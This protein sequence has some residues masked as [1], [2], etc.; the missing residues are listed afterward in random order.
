[1]RTD[2]LI[3]DL[4]AR[5]WP[6]TRPAVRL[7]F[8]MIAAWVVSF[9][10]LVV[11]RGSPLAAVPETGVTPFAMKLGYSLALAMLAGTAAFAAGRPGQSPWR[12]AMLLALPF[13]VILASAMIELAQE[14]REAWMGMLFG[15]SFLGCIAAIS[16]AS[17]PVFGALVWAFRELAPTRPAVAGFLIGLSAGGAGAVAYA[18][19]CDETTASFLLASYTAGVL[20]PAVVGAL[21]GRRILRW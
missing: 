3:A 5:P 14:P 9:A 10:G 11:L 20:V 16:I 19:Y 7:A 6:A 13:A 15:S 2:E 4:A 18:L 17:L 12:R 8:A 21:F 1:M